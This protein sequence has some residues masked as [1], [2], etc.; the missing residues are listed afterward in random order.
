MKSI[1]K[2]SV[3]LCLFIFFFSSCSERQEV[4]V[5]DNEMLYQ[6]IATSS[7]YRAYMEAEDRHFTRAAE[8]NVDYEAL[9]D[10]INNKGEFSCTIKDEALKNIKGAEKYMEINCETDAVFNTFLRKY[11]E[12]LDLNREQRR[13][14]DIIYKEQQIN[15]SV[16]D[17]ILNQTNIN[18]Y[19][20]FHC[21]SDFSDSTTKAQD[22]YDEM[23]D[24]C[25]EFM[26]ASMARTIRRILIDIA[27]TIYEECVEDSE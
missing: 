15:S 20:E 9:L 24:G 19:A 1:I 17:K 12:Y 25:E 2:N 23:M 10:Y 27:I 18:A 6:K 11:P 26:C 21:L 13:E 3:T 4:G 14:I 5:I 7:S 8:L 16:V 22:K